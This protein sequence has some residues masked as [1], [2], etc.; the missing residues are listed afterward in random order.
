MSEDEHDE[1]SAAMK[2]PYRYYME[3]GKRNRLQTR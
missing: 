2:N 1:L 3:G